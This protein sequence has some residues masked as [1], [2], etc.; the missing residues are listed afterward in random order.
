MCLDN[1]II[2]NNIYTKFLT[3]IVD[4]ILYWKPHTDRLINKLSTTCYVIRSV[5]PYVNT[6]AIIMIYHSL[7]HNIMTYGIIFWGN[8]SHNNQV[9]GMQIKAIT[10]I[11]GCGNRES[12]RNSFKE[13]NL[14]ATGVT[15]CNFFTYI[16]VK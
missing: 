9:F 3:L 5:K 14:F 12:C 6:N 15:T 11:V 10:T 7:F 4:N 8:S 16:C 13:L 1:N 2:S